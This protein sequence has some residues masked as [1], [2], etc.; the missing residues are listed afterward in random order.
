MP[1][2]EIRRLTIDDYDSMI[3][4]WELAGLPHRPKGRDSRENTAKQMKLYPEFY[5]GAFHGNK[6]VGVVIASYETRMKGWINRLAVDPAYQRQGIAEQL[7]RKAEESLKTRGAKI[8]CAL[9]ELPND[10]SVGLFQKMG[11]ALYRD[12]L[13]VTKRESKDV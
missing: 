1:K 13:Y 4:A 5:L 3:N 7:I 9:I 11:Y 2:V 6:L 12:I 8:F 10:K